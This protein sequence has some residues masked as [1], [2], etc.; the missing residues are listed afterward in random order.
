[1]ITLFPPCNSTTGRE[2]RVSGSC[3]SRV[4]P[5]YRMRT[6][7]LYVRATYT[8]IFKARTG[9][10]ARGLAGDGARGHLGFL[11][12]CRHFISSRVNTENPQFRRLADGDTKIQKWR[13]CEFQ[14]TA[15]S[16]FHSVGSTLMISILLYI[17][18][19]G[20]LCMC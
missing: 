19:R 1:M 3:V 16:H 5:H 20:D 7:N 14:L 17:G 9:V 18:R 11:I 4:R 12:Y 8:Y 15:F 2:I 10:L 13:D 6:C